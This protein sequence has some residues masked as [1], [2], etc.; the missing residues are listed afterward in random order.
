MQQ[1]D[2]KFW[3]QFLSDQQN[4]QRQ[5]AAAQS[6]QW[7]QLMPALAAPKQ[8]NNAALMAAMMQQNAQQSQQ[9]MQ[10]MIAMISQMGQQSQ[11]TMVGMMQAI[12]TMINANKDDG[13]QLAAIMESMKAQNN[14]TTT[15][16]S[17]VLTA[18]LGQQD[19][20]KQLELF[21]QFKELSG[22]DQNSTLGD[23]AK[24][25]ES[26]E[27][28][29]AIKSLAESAG[30]R[31]EG[32][33]NKEPPALAPPPP[34][35]APAATGAEPPNPYINP[36]P[37]PA[38]ATVEGAEAKALQV[39]QQIAAQVAGQFNAGADPLAFAASYWEENKEH[40]G[41][42][43]QLDPQSVVLIVQ[44]N[45]AGWQLPQLATTAGL[46]YMTTFATEVK[47][48]ADSAS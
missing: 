20:S 13:T 42:I 4:A 33:D 38:P 44:A 6:N 18:A 39:V 34:P 23:I 35:G 12:A 21:K 15:L 25:I 37:A 11:Q 31:L 3:L 17:T 36:N 27:I 9:Q 14:Q 28:G 45:A 16:L 1:S 10:L 29:P 24:L 22:D 47:R 8:D 46:Q 19:F 41:I 2:S 43:D 40:K 5:D 48:L 30:K 26:A 32:G 7:L